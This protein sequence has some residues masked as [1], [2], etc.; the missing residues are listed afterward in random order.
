MKGLRDQRDLLARLVPPAH[1]DLLA[2]LVT[3]V[4]GASLVN[5]VWLEPTVSLD[6]L[7]LLSCCRSVS[8]RVVEI[9]AL[10]FRHRRPRRPPSCHRLGWP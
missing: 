4:R 3:L 10:S 7:D 1:L 8:V 2:L 6:L 5:L 9:R